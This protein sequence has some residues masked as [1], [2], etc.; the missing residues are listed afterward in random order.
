[1]ENPVEEDSDSDG[2][3]NGVP[4]EQRI[5]LW[6]ENYVNQEERFVSLL[7]FKSCLSL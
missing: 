1:M 4:K 2:D 6:G 5:Q 7:L 3:E